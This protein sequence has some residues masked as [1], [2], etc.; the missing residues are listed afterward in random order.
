MSSS[1]LVVY[2]T[3][4]GTDDA[5]A[6]FMLIKAE[7]EYNVKILGV[8]IVHGNTS[9]DYAAEN[10]LRVLSSADRLDI[11]VYKGAAEP[12]IRHSQK[13]FYHGINGFGDVCFPTNPDLSLIKS[14]NAV[15]YLYR[16]VKENPKQVS[17]L[18]VGP[19]TNIA[20]A[21]KTFPDFIEL[22]KD[23]FI[24]GGNYNAVGNCKSECAE[25]N[26]FTDPDA[27]YVVLNNSKCKLTIVPWEACMEQSIEIPMSFRFNEIANIK[28]FV[29]DL[30]NPVDEAIF[31]PKN[32]AMW[33]SCDAFLVAVFLLKDKAIEKLRKCFASVEL[34]G[35]MTRGQV[36][37]YHQTGSEKE[38]NVTMIENIKSESCKNLLLW[39]AT[40]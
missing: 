29:T 37:I 27:A 38:Y 19:L 40:P 24:M 33:N 8:T 23:I 36:V 3:D 18:C 15:S 13:N 17:L 22:V 4:M 11:C 32:K 25:F 9:L 5:W 21:M 10:A 30:M 20:L 2:D 12:M 39:T 14:E 26:F 6:L 31:K 34:N 7:K 1:E 16:V 35:E 28:S